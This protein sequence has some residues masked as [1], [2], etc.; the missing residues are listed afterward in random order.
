MS[1][2]FDLTKR[3]RKKAFK[4]GLIK[5]FFCEKETNLKKKNFCFSSIKKTVITILQNIFLKV[6]IG[7]EQLIKIF[8]MIQIGI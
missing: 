2:S 6:S 3:M 5:A 4:N 7:F 1:F 8:Q